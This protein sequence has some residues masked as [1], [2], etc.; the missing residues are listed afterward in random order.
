MGGGFY[1]PISKFQP[2]KSSV[3]TIA[4]SYNKN[5]RFSP[6]AAFLVRDCFLITLPSLLEHCE[7]NSGHLDVWCCTELAD[8]LNLDQ[9]ELAESTSHFQALPD[10]VH[11]LSTIPGN[12]GLLKSQPLRNLK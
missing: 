10:G 11:Q 3:E 6:I 5:N 9:S 1:L 2:L 12:Q 4:L 7:Y 8:S